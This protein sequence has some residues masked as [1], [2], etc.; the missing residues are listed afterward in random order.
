MSG[1]LYIVATPIGNLGDISLRAIDTL[2]QVDLIAAEDT[3]HSQRLLNHLGIDNKLIS[4]HEHNERSRL[5]GLLEKLNSGLDIALISD[6]GTPLISDPG[7]VLVNAV[8]EAGIR[9]S[10][11]PGASSIIAAL[12]ASGLATDKFTYLGFLPQKNG[13]RLSRL[14]AIR[15]YKGT[16]VLLESSHRIE[17]LLEQLIEKLPLNKI[18][19]AK[20][21]TKAHEKILRGKAAEILPAF[22]QDVTLRKGEFVVIIENPESGDDNPD[23]EQ[24]TRLLG[25]LL[26]ELPLKKAVQL[27]VRIS[28]GKKNH[29]YQ[30]ALKIEAEASRS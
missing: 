6:A 12:C 11:V 9:V 1:V 28:G 17:R 8:A 29:L 24:A 7:Y 13:E 21:L 25:L 15:G 20:E 23:D 16:L 10:P 5:K 14:D 22:E 26:P 30:L 4:V 19:V 27:A 2:K 18:V 3:R